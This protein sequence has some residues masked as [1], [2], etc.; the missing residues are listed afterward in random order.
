MHFSWRRAA[1]TAISRSTEDAAD[2]ILE[3]AEYMWVKRKP[4]PVRRQHDP[5]PNSPVVARVVPT[6]LAAPPDKF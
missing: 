3:F 6:W 2:L 1:S 5:I 4:R